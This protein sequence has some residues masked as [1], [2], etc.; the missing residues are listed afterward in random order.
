MSDEAVERLNLWIRWA[1]QAIILLMLTWAGTELRDLRTSV[2]DVKDDV[3]D[4]KS[5]VIELRSELK[6]QST[7]QGYVDGVQNSRLT[8][9][10]AERRREQQRRFPQ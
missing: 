4:V 6:T 7:V 1:L 5:Q 3:G 10:E 2:G 9:L 8:E